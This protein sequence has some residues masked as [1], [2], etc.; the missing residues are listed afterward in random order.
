LGPYF[1]NKLK[2]E[3]IVGRQMSERGG[4]VECFVEGEKVRLTGTAIISMSGM[5]WI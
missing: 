4:F 5:L 1:A 2:K 3:D